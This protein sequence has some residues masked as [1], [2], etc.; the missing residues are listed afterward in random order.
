MHNEFFVALN[1]TNLVE[2]TFDSKEKGEITRTCAPMDF[3]PSRRYSSPEV[4]YH[5]MD[6]DSSSGE[7]PL[8]ITPEQV[9][10]IRTLEDKFSPAELV[11]WEPNWHYARDWGDYS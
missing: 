8:S 5:F 6:L 10:S 7:H 9:I 4:R 3:G 1:G 11:K 2:L